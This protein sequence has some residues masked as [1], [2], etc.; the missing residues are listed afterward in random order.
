[1]PTEGKE[2]EIAKLLLEGAAP[3]D[4]VRRD[5]AHGTVY[6][7]WARLRKGGT[8]LVPTDLGRESSAPDIESEPEIIELRKDL[9]KAELQREVEEVQ[10]PSTMETRLASLEQTVR[11]LRAEL[12]RS[13]KRR[14]LLET[15]I[16]AL[17]L[18]GLRESF[19]CWCGAHGFVAVKVVCTGCG[20]ETA[21]GRWPPRGGW[22]PIRAT[23]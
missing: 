1:M 20:G 19:R 2:E 23:A 3:A 8:P 5:Y 14:D 16:D 15:R 10:G 11:E 4:L 6:K 22:P 13:S 9:R 21:Y 7:V 17:P 18:A 12:A